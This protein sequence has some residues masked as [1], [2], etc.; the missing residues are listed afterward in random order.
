[1]TTPRKSE[2][3]CQ[4]TQWVWQTL[5][6]TVLAVAVFIGAVMVVQ[7]ARHART[8]RADASGQPGATT[9]D[10]QPQAA[11]QTD[12]AVARD[13]DDD[14]GRAVIDP[15]WRGTF[16]TSLTR[17]TLERSLEL[18]ARFLLAH[19][20]PAGNFTYEYD[21]TTDSYSSGDNQVRQAGAMWGLA[22]IY[23]HQPTAARA[24]ALDKALRFFESHARTNRFG[25]RYTVYPGDRAGSTGTVALVALAHIDY[26]RA[27]AGTLDDARRAELETALDGYIKMLLALRTP[28]GLWY[29]GYHFDDG[30]G[31]GK[32]SPYADGEALLALVKAAKYLGYD[33]LRGRILNAADA[34]YEYNIA[35]ALAQN[36][37]SDTTKGYYQWSSM[38]FYELATSG[39]PNT[40]KYGTYVIDLAN[41]MIDV[42]RTLARTR[43][44]AYAYE[45]IIHAYKL[46]LDR[47]DAEHARKFAYVIETGLTKLTSWQVGGPMPNEFIR[48][49]TPAMVDHD[50]SIGGIQN[51]ASEAPLRIDVTQHQMA[52]VIL[53]LKYY[54]TA[55]TV[56]QPEADEVD[57]ADEG[58]LRID[59]R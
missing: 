22:L 35:R 4:P 47:G 29:S 30:A 36:P 18:G 27:A 23:Q 51:H 14:D 43:N 49:K 57:E 21:W 53:A 24:A 9:S 11:A 34:G 13:G 28:E 19:Q 7:M 52:A 48:A 40:Y 3:E 58:M 16:S 1:M 10:S 59:P 31:Y 5:A 56:A 39:W 12:E 2:T 20:Q 55:E 32:P 45:G 50:R 15:H 26:L 17:Q 42:H 33:D 54:Y 25:E 46:A 38:A 8:V 44:T 37:D 6:G 41:W